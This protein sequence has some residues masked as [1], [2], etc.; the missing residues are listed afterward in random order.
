MA[1]QRSDFAYELP[2][3]LI[4]QTPAERRPESRLL[5]LDPGVGRVHHAR[6]G[7]L[8]QWLEPGDLVILNDTRVIAARLYARKDSGGE[9]ELLLERIESDHVA[10]FQVRASK[11][12]KPGRQLCVVLQDGTLVPPPMAVLGREGEFYRLQFGLPVLSVL[13][14]HGQVPLPP[15]IERMPA[16]ADADRYQTVY[17][18]AEGAVAA[19]TAGLHFD[20]EMLDLL[21]ASGVETATVTLHVGA[22]TFQPMRTHEIAAHRMHTEQ[23]S[24]PAAT[25]NAIRRCRARARRVIAVGTTVV[26]VLESVAQHGELSAFEGESDIFIYPGHRFRVVDAL[27]TNFHLPESTLLMLVSAFAGRERV[28]AAYREAVR[29]RY[30][31]F[32]YG[33]A[34]FITARCES[35]A[36]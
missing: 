5:V 31:F 17:A 11:P 15:Y 8:G 6:F 28:L 21:R 13:K 3:E 12:L 7:D 36:V 30:R 35:H 18:R 10:L 16:A 24:L 9:A 22:G 1:L 32:S 19:P 26:R 2:I 23:I 27:L 34:M 33:D 14:Q 4:A 20:E 29:E 25:A